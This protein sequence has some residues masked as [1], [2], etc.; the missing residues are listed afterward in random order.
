MEWNETKWNKQKQKTKAEINKQTNKQ[1]NKI[2][3]KKQI[4]SRA[5]MAYYSHECPFLL[6]GE[7]GKKEGEIRQKMGK[8]MN[9]EN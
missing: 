6:S 4:C 1:T 2:W 5:Y 7:N 8:T 9:E 3:F